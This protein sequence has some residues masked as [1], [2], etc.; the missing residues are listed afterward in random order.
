MLKH[1]IEMMDDLKKASI[2]FNIKVSP[3]GF[4]GG[5]PSWNL[6]FE[7]VFKTQNIPKELTD[8]YNFFGR[9]E[10]LTARYYEEFKAQSE[11]FFDLFKG[12]A[13]HIQLDIP[14][15]FFDQIASDEKRLRTK[16][17]KSE[18]KKIREQYRSESFQWIY[19][20]EKRLEI[21]EAK[22]RNPYF[23]KKI[24]KDNKGTVVFGNEKGPETIR[25]LS[26]I[27]SLR[28]GIKNLTKST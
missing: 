3:N 6:R 16:Y 23:A 7:I 26:Q 27:N 15:D 1:I 11:L 28:C 12:Y 25:I 2:R 13:D 14:R 10:F 22:I 4:F 20:L 24:I 19:N 18:R 9:K 8:K 17:D 21:L 5:R